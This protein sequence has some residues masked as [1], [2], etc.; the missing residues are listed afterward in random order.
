MGTHPIFESDFD[1]LTDL[2][3][4][5]E[6]LNLQDQNQHQKMVSSKRNSLCRSNS[7]STRPSQCA[8]SHRKLCRQKAV[9]SRPSIQ[10]YSPHS[11]TESINEEKFLDK[12]NL[13]DLEV[14]EK[15]QGPQSR[16]K[17][18][19]LNSSFTYRAITPVVESVLE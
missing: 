2:R 14:V 3:Q 13:E 10:T 1:C 5:L 7:F 17:S 18:A 9:Y 16:L 12:K 15:N 11:S 8:R 6:G 19:S 4:D